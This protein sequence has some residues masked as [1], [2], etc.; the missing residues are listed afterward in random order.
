[1]LRK[2][3]FLLLPVITGLIL[4]S[5]TSP[6]DVAANRK[7]VQD[8]Q[9]SL[10]FEP[11]VMDLGQQKLNQSHTFE[12][13]LQ[14]TSATQSVD[15]TSLRFKNATQEFTIGGPALPLRLEPMQTL[16]IPVT[17][18]ASQP[19]TYMDT[20]L[21]NSDGLASCP[22]RAVVPAVDYAIWITDMNFGTCDIGQTKTV[23]GAIHNE[24]D[25]IAIIQSIEI[26]Q[27]ATAVFTFVPI[28][29][30]IVLSAGESITFTVNA[31]PLSTGISEATI[32]MVVNYKGTGEIDDTGSLY[33]DAQ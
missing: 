29:M 3:S 10:N 4:W 30:P 15:I 14:N 19:G 33:I 31:V 13:T 24:G 8:E 18:L 9:T 23:T 7:V 27:P 26:I 2:L 22:V 16:S 25:D 17:F 12:V 20:L 32:Q 5:C 21:V 1:M 11:K 28:S 6:T